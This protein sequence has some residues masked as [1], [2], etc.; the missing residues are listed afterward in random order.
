MVFK[1]QWIAQR[2]GIPLGLVT[3]IKASDNVAAAVADYGNKN[4]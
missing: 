4:A 3:R 2:F 1:R